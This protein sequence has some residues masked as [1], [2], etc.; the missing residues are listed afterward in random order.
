MQLSSDGENTLDDVAI[1]TKTNM[2]A[3]FSMKQNL[4]LLMK[5]TRFLRICLYLLL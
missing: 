1:L 2:S 5:H 4:T 3:I